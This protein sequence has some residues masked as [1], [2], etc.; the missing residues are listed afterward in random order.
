MKHPFE[1]ALEAGYFER[2]GH[3]VNL[4]PLPV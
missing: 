2:V 1:Q 3:A 4:A